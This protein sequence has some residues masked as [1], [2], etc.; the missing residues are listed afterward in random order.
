MLLRAIVKSNRVSLALGREEFT[1]VQAAR[2]V[3][4]LCAVGGIG[5]LFS[6]SGNI[7]HLS[8]MAQHFVG[9][10]G[11]GNRGHGTPTFSTVPGRQKSN[12][13]GGNCTIPLAEYKTSSGATPKLYSSCAVGGRDCCRY[14]AS[15]NFAWW[16]LFTTPESRSK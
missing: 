7:M 9:G 16:L 15:S 3:E 2:A 8:G 13:G 6:G 10:V 12:S 4:G 1:R 14:Q 5:R 11:T